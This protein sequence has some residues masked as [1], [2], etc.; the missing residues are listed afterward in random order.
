MSLSVKAAS[1]GLLSLTTFIIGAAFFQDCP[2]QIGIPIFLV[3]SGTFGLTACVVH[4][5]CVLKR[6]REGTRTWLK[7]VGFVVALL[8]FGAGQLFVYSYMPDHYVNSL[9][10][11]HVIL[12]NYSFG[13][14]I[15]MYFLVANVVCKTWRNY[16]SNMVWMSGLADTD[17][18]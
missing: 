14:I 8:W 11:C 4:V 3:G 18:T 2:C 15:F 17:N 6:V 1:F 10:C 16:M 12:F 5:Y 7:R 9:R 13:Y